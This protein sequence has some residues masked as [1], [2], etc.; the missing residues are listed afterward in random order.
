MP[1]ECPGVPT[2]V[3]NPRN[4][5]EDKAAYDDKAKYLGSLFGKNFDKYQ[6]GVSEEIRAAAPK[7]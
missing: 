5:W 2:E 3:L 1:K 6:D 4:T 7:L